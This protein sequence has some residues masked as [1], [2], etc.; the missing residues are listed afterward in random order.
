MKVNRIDFVWALQNAALF[1]DKK[2]SAG[3]VVQFDAH[4]GWLTI[5]ST[6]DFVVI[7]HRIRYSG[8][9]FSGALEVALV[10]ENA[11]IH[12]DASM[13]DTIDLVPEGFTAAPWSEEFATGVAALMDPSNYAGGD[14]MPFAVRPERFRKFSLIK[15]GDYPIDFLPGVVS[16]PGAGYR[17]ILRFKAGPD[18]RGVLAPILRSRLEDEFSEDVL[19]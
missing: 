14:W 16:V 2:S 19:W 15:P 7:T 13:G 10:K 12:A 11:K 18:V 3:G 4:D 17:D 8:Q 9:A 1:A 6:D 5:T